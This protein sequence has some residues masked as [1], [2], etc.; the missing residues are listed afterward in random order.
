MNQPFVNDKNEIA[1]IYQQMLNEDMTAGDVYGGDVAGHAGIENTDWFAP[2]D[3][4]NPYGMGVT[5]R[6]GKLKRKRKKLKKKIIENYQYTGNCVE[7][8]DGMQ[9]QQITQHD[10]WS[11]PEETYGHDPEMQISGDVFQ[12]MTG[13]ILKDGELAFWNQ[14]MN[15]VFRYNPDEDV[16][17][18]YEK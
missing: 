5:T 13:E 9:I 14:D 2:G 11:F 6:R 16:H 10:E 8:D 15:I 7:C 18:F 3:A 4:R 17:Y 12:Q 1:N